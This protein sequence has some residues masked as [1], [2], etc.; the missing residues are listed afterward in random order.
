MER[1]TR[2]VSN[3]QTLEKKK[4]FDGND[5][6]VDLNFGSFILSDVCHTVYIYSE[7]NTGRFFILVGF[8]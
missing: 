8:A 7:L 4:K 6:L 1:M 3:P 5:L 2:R